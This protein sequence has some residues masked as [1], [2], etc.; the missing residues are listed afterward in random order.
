MVVNLW[1]FVSTRNMADEWR[2]SGVQRTD[3]RFRFVIDLVTDLIANL[4]PQVK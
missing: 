2:L 4:G 3:R 1:T